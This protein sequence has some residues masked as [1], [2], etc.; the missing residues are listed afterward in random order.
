MAVA[1]QHIPTAIA[2][3]YFLGYVKATDERLNFQRPPGAGGL[4]LP[5]VRIPRVYPTGDTHT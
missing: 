5:G 3:A 1:E 2:S 4:H